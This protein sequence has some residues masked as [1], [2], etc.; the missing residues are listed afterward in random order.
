[1]LYTDLVAAWIRGSRLGRLYDTIIAGEAM[2]NKIMNLTEF[3]D[4]QAGTPQQSM[5]LNEILPSQ[6]QVFVSAQVPADKIILLDKRFAL[7]KLTSAPLLVEGEKIVSKQ[8]QGSYASIT[9]GFANIFRDA[10]VVIDQSL[11]R[12]DGGGNDFPSWMTPTL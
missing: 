7:V 12:V 5:V 9:T 6:S 3:K 8:I 11:A 1:L 2:A 4:K 10:R